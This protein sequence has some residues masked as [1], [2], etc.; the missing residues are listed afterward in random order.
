MQA[1]DSFISPIPGFEV[2]ILIPAIPISTRSLSGEFA[3]D[4]STGANARASKTRTDKWKAATN[5]TPQKKTK[6]ATG[7]SSSGIKINELAPKASPA[8]TP[9][10]DS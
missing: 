5:P 6:K 1:F 2:D 4:P 9:P 7:K 8:P 10:L 3:N